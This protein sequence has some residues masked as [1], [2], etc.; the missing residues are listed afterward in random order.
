MGNLAK[1]TN[2]YFYVIFLLLP[3]CGETEMKFQNNKYKK[4]RF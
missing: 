1:T 3:S 4:S 2:P